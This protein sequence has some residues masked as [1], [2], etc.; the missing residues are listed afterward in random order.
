MSDVTPILQAIALVHE[1]YLR[2]APKKSN[3]GSA[4]E[5]H[6]WES[7]GHCYAADCNQFVK[8]PLYALSENVPAPLLDAKS[9]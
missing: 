1:A 9:R 5:L 3:D 6:P 8:R 4:H 7:K 2:F